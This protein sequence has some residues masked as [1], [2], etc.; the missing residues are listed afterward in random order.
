MEKK[1]LFEDFFDA[2]GDGIFVADPQGHLTAVNKKFADMLGYGPKELLCKH[3]SDISVQPI[4]G[5]YVDSV[6]STVR[7]T[8]S[9]EPAGTHEIHY[10]RKDGSLFFAEVTSTFLRDADQNITES[11]GIV[12]DIT[13]HKKLEAMLRER[14]E[15]LRK[16]IYADPNLIFVKH[17]SGKYVAVSSSLARIFGTTVDDVIGKTDLDFAERRKMS[18]RE[19]RQIREDDLEVITTGKPKHIPDES[20]TQPDGTVIWYQ[21]T[22]V[23][24][25]RNN[26]QDY[27]LGVAVDITERKRSA[28]LLKQRERELE[29]TNENLAEV[30]A[31]LKVLLKQK[32]DDRIEL[33][34]KMLSNIKTLVAPYLEKLQ[35]LCPDV[36][37]R[38]IITIVEKNLKEIISPFSRKLSSHFINLT[39]AEIKVADLIKNGCHNKEIAGHLNIASG[40]VEA[41]RKNIRKKL[42]LQNTKTNLRSYLKSIQ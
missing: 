35:Q 12:R 24:L 38:N 16:I 10:K 1:I 34:E 41:H 3:A 25:S 5:F 30:N 40:T 31:A 37:R 2:V 32:D 7:S 33:E 36:R 39:S 6:V 18:V 21:T 26:E 11:I 15:F 9:G 14:E 8:E 42:G 22:K 4:P 17:R 28:D 23:P 19:A 20:I 27:V 13:E 29:V